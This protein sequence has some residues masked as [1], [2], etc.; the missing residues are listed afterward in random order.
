MTRPAELRS[1]SHERGLSHAITGRRIVEQFTE[2]ASQRRRIPG[3]GDTSF[4]V[5]V[6][7]PLDRRHP[8]RDDRSSGG[9]GAD[10]DA[11]RGARGPVRQ[12]HDGG[13]R[14]QRAE[15]V[16][17]D[18]TEPSWGDRHRV[19]ARAQRLEPGCRIPVAGDKQ[20]QVLRNRR[21]A[22][23][24][25]GARR[26][27]STGPGT[28]R[29][30]R[31][32]PAPASFPERR[33]IPAEVQTRHTAGDLRRPRRDSLVA[34]DEPVAGSARDQPANGGIDHRREHPVS[35]DR[36]DARGPAHEARSRLMREL[37]HVVS[38]DD[39]VPAQKAGHDGEP[40]D[41]AIVGPQLDVHRRRR[42][43]R[44]PVGA[45]RREGRPAPPEAPRRPA[46]SL[47]PPG[48]GRAPHRRHGRRPR[49]H[50]RVG[51]TMKR[52]ALSQA[53]ST[54]AIRKK[55]QSGCREHPRQFD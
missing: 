45:K 6:D 11:A 23:R 46:G 30:T 28:L 31:A 8:R 42:A 5:V 19:R 32:G 25:R 24:H 38:D 36:A 43:E 21:P 39:A 9:H 40:E 48:P 26:P 2:C 37:R 33:Q 18:R 22:P 53:R 29:T 14:E 12:N 15:V 17:V 20:R 7:E 10:D 54:Q 1:R 4:D 47:T 16:L 13:L 34:E 44:S 27:P 50:L 41:R 49:R 52:R 55:S 51:P 35:Q 3:R